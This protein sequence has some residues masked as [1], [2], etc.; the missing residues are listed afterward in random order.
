MMSWIALPKRSS[1]KRTTE[2]ANDE[3][4]EDYGVNDFAVA[5]QQKDTQINFGKDTRR[6]M[7]LESTRLK[8]TDDPTTDQPPQIGQ[9]S[10]TD[11][12]K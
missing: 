11:T 8:G 7:T 2:D 3:K 1:R 10:Q 5:V 12:H 4:I 6:E 9:I